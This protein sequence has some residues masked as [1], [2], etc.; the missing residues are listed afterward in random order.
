M[1]KLILKAERKCILK[2]CSFELSPGKNN[3]AFSRHEQMR[4]LRACPG[5]RTI[6]PYAGTENAL[7]LLMRRAFSPMC[8]LWASSGQAYGRLGIFNVVYR[9]FLTQAMVDWRR[10]AACSSFDS[11]HKLCMWRWFIVWTRILAITNFTSRRSEPETLRLIEV[12]EEMYLRG[13]MKKAEWEKI[14][15]K[16]STPATRWHFNLS[17]VSHM[18]RA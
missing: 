13:T 1:K 14:K 6:A 18:G 4:I 8:F 2:P 10:D 11:Q 15:I 17:T 16:L 3:W 12:I 9:I 7:C 5:H